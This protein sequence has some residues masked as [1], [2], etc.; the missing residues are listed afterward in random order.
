MLVR[1]SQTG[2]EADFFEVEGSGCGEMADQHCMWEGAVVGLLTCLLDVM[3]EDTF[4]LGQGVGSHVFCIRRQGFDFLLEKRES[5]HD[6]ANRKNLSRQ[7]T[8]VI[9]FGRKSQ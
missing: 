1:V 5:T 3:G 2:V 8:T 4:S 6:I 7:N 9:I